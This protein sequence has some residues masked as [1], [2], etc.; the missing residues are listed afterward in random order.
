MDFEGPLPEPPLLPVTFNDGFNGGCRLGLAWALLRIFNES[1]TGQEKLAECGIGPQETFTLE[2]SKQPWALPPP[3]QRPRLPYAERWDCTGAVWEE[4]ETLE[5]P[6]WEFAAGTGEGLSPLPFP[7]P[8]PFCQK[9]SKP[10]PAP[11]P[12]PKGNEEASWGHSLLKCPGTPQWK[13]AG[14]CTFWVCIGCAGRF[15]GG[16]L[17]AGW[18]TGWVLGLGPCTTCF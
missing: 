5:A 16:W 13:H 14:R 1:V 9:P 15:A 12:F 6:I 18:E 2:G 3:L 10:L 11:L 7:F 4:T 17:T 8:F